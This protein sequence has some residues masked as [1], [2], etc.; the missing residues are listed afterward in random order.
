MEHTTWRALGECWGERERSIAAVVRRGFPLMSER[1]SAHWERGVFQA[2]AQETGGRDGAIC[3]LE[4]LTWSLCDQLEWRERAS[5]EFRFDGAVSFDCGRMAFQGEYL[6]DL[7][8]GAFVEFRMVLATLD[9][10]THI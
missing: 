10:A 2:P 4:R 3:R 5:V 7:T 6:R 8:T 9:P 1:G